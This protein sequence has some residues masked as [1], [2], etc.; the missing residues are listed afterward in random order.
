[1]PWIMYRSV[2][3][4]SRSDRITRRSGWR[5]CWMRRLA[6]R[7]LKMFSEVASVMTSSPSFAP[8]RP[9]SLSPSRDG[10]SNQPAVFQLRIRPVPHS[11]VMTSA[12]RAA[13]ARG[14]TP[15]ELPSM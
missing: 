13:A 10:S 3:K 14:I 12:A 2:G 9:A 8:S 6:A 15:S 1:M 11:W 4:L 5:F 7:A